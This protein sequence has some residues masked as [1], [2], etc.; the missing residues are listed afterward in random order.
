MKG[1]ENEI[2]KIKIEIILGRAQCAPQSADLPNFY[3][4]EMMMPMD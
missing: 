4:I 1:A 2:L 3:G